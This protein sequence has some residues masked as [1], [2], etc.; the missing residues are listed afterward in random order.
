[1]QKL[2]APSLQDLRAG[3]WPVIEPA[4]TIDDAVAQ[5]VLN[6]ACAHVQSVC[7]RKASD[8]ERAGHEGD[9]VPLPDVPE[10]ILF[11]MPSWIPAAMQKR[12]VD[13]LGDVG[14]PFSKI[15][16]SNLVIAR[17]EY[18]EQKGHAPI[19]SHPYA[20]QPPHRLHPASAVAIASH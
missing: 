10:H 17:T 13:A 20:D 5:A 16:G 7:A 3:K 18:I 8:W 11:P 1:M 4:E 12:I 19:V 6:Q 14:F 15:S 2:T 9:G